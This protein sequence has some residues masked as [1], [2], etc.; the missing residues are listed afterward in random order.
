MTVIKPVSIFSL[1]LSLTGNSLIAQSASVSGSAYL[2]GENNHGGIKVAFNAV[3]PT[4]VSDSAFTDSTGAYSINLY[5]GTYGVTFSIVD[6]QDLV[7]SPEMLISGTMQLDP[8][9]LSS[10]PIRTIS[11]SVKGYWSSDSTY[12]VNGNME[13]PSGD[14][15]TIE[16]GTKVE[17]EGL[18]VFEV[19]GLLLAQGTEADSIY[20]TSS[21]RAKSPGDWYGIT[22]NGT[23]DDNSILSYCVAEYGSTTDSSDSD[24]GG[25]VVCD[26]ANPTIENSRIR[27]SLR[28]GV[29]CRNSSPTLINNEI[30]HNHIYGIYGHYAEPIVIGNNIY[31]NNRSGIYLYNSP[32]PLINN[33]DIFDN[34]IEGILIYGKGGGT[35][36]GN[37]LYN[38][39]Y[40]IKCRGGADPTITRNDI[41]HNYQGIVVQNASSPWIENNDIAS[42]SN[43]GIVVDYLSSF[44]TITMNIVMGSTIGINSQ[45]RPSEVSYNLIWGNVDD[46]QGETPLGVGI[47]ITVNSNGDSVDAYFNLFQDPL[48]TSIEPENS[49]FLLLTVESPCIDAGGTNLMETDTSDIGSHPYDP[50]ALG[51]ITELN[52]KPNIYILS[53]AYPNPF[54]PNTTINYALKEDVRASL[55]VYDLLGRE[56]RVLVNEHQPAAYY[57]VVW[58]GR[59]R[60]GRPLPSGVYIARL[61]ATPTAGVAGDFV[62]GIKMVLLK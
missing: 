1:I 12:S 50:T 20:F 51:V 36:N 2:E 15:L 59:D 29:F 37:S 22:F 23:A 27:H 25:L 43:A 4:A 47:L 31:G 11:G 6:F 53:P 28:N 35:I 54:N 33:N 44:P 30:S 14:T 39:L 21:G 7:Y 56:V 5:P 41:Y 55:K 61:H 60:S 3:S 38:N 62:A 40:G 9:T 57:S 18:F 19:S 26:H 16:A 58:D 52:T 34:G 45:I 8:I 42:N 17:F 48:L 10:R 13:V 49:S 24:V 32:A 46:F